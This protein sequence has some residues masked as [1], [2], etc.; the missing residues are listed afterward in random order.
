[1]DMNE[2]YKQVPKE[3]LPQE[4]GGNLPCVRTIHEETVDRLK[5]MND[6]FEA[7]ELQRKDIQLDGTYIKGNS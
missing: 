2:F 4:Y 1:M 6:F 5:E 3:C 7:E